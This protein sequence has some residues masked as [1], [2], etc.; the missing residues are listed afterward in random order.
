[1]KFRSKNKSSY[2]EFKKPLSPP[3]GG[4]VYE[5]NNGNNLAVY[6]NSEMT[7]LIRNGNLM[8][9]DCPEVK[10]SVGKIE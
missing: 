2:Y 5:S 10:I 6:N 8:R 1:M 3:Y 7:L 9:F 4:M